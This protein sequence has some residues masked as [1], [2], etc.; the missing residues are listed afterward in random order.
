MVMRNMGC[1]KAVGASVHLGLPLAA[2]RSWRTVGPALG[3]AKQVAEDVA[4]AALTGSAAWQAQTTWTPASSVM[5]YCC[6][7]QGHCTA[8]MACRAGPSAKLTPQLRAR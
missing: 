2:T 7:T 3:C 4:V 8:L 6:P 5:P 1:R